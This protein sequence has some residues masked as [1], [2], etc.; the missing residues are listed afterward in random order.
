MKRDGRLISSLPYQLH[1]KIQLPQLIAELQQT[2]DLR[3]SLAINPPCRP[4]FSQLG[5][6]LGR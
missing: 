4:R 6:I 2:L 1:L 5:R 3:G